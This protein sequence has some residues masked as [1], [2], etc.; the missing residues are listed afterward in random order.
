MNALLIVVAVVA[1]ILLITGGVSQSL[2]FLLW[3]GG[4]LL[5]IAI[6]LFLVR[7]LTGRRTL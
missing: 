7:A 2:S 6:V 3:I 1:I 5:V 4:I